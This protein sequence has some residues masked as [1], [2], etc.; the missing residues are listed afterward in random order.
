[1]VP[2]VNTIRRQS[3]ESSVAIPF[4]RSF[5]PVGANYQPQAADELARFRFCGCGWP[6][7]LLLPKGTTQGMV[8]DLFVMIS[9]YS[10]DSVEQPNTLVAFQRFPQDDWLIFLFLFI[11]S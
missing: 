11:F 10:Q 6:Q 7:H 5:R 1:M 4:E 9:D 3:T 8:F 2:G